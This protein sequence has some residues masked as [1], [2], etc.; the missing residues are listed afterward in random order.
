MLASRNSGPWQKSLHE[1]LICYRNSTQATKGRSPAELFI[2]R[3]LR[4]RLDLLKPDIYG[5]ID[6]NV[7]RQESHQIRK[8]KPRFFEEGE[9]V[10]V[11]RHPEG[12]GYEAGEIIRKTGRWSYRVLVN[13]KENR[14]HADHIRKV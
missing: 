10:W 2:G 13:G 8:C 12:R 6:K 3:K 1:F 7:V 5:T 4:T 9:R 14:K 11:L